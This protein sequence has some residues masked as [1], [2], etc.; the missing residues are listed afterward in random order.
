MPP[1]C[2]NTTLTG[3]TPNTHQT[4]RTPLPY[5]SPSAPAC[6]IC[7][8]TFAALTGSGNAGT[9]TCSVP[10]YCELLV[11]SFWAP[12]VLVHVAPASSGAAS[13]GA[14]VPQIRL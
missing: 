4:V 10:R 11:T 7:V 3:P 14:R 12:P 5:G 6:V 9:V 1:L 13:S 8:R 2:W